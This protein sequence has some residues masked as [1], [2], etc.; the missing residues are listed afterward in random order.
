MIKIR[1]RLPFQRRIVVIA[2]GLVALSLVLFVRWLDP[3]VV[4]VARFL[5]FDQYQRW[6]PRVY[7][8]APVRVIS[9]DEDSLAKLGQWPW[10]RHY[11]A[12]LIDNLTVMGAATIAFDIIFAE[13][14]RTSPDTVLND[15]PMSD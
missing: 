12:Q 2:T 1:S 9:I 6:Q 14:D 4:S 10:P 3:G 15:W 13:P 5:V 7:E 8:P 11:I